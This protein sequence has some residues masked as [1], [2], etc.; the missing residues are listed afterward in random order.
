MSVV[1]ARL[2]DVATTTPVYLEIGAKKVFACAYDW[3]G[4]CRAGRDP[5]RALEALADYLPRYA[6]VVRRARLALPGDTFDIVDEVPGTRG[7]TDFGAPGE[8]APRDLGP[9]TAKAAGRLA[10]LVEAAWAELDATIAITPAQLR[11]GPRG[12]GRDRDKMADHVLGAEAAYARKIGVKHRQPALHDTAA[13]AAMR[14]DIA[15]A[16]RTPPTDP[17]WPVP[18]AA[19]RV[20]WHVLDHAWEMADRTE[21]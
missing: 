15:A 1:A 4:W 2:G 6:P 11:K 12:G 18:Y 16:I 10:T 5:A 17:G 9:L 13:I 14:A 20:A 21:T 8:V 7:L 19:R 3:P